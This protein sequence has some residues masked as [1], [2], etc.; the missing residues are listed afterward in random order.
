MFDEN[1]L[2]L[3]LLYSIPLACYGFYQYKCR[4]AARQKAAEQATRPAFRYQQIQAQLDAVQQKRERIEELNRLITN[5]KVAAENPSD[6]ETVAISYLDETGHQRT[7][8]SSVGNRTETLV[9]FAAQERD[10]LITS[11]QADLRQLQ[12]QAG[13]TDRQNEQG[14]GCRNR[15]YSGDD[16][17]CWTLKHKMSSTVNAVGS[18]SAA[19]KN[20]A[21]PHL[22]PSNT[23]RPAKK[24][25]TGNRKL[26]TANAANK[27]NS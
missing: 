10:A 6:W 25:S 21:M 15:L 22:I 9:Q 14:S 2:K 13:Q 1:L 19:G 3:A 12:G 11:L 16:A 5:L 4:Q 20:W 17:A 18:I 26:T 24:K 27:W 8:S 23:A 7:V